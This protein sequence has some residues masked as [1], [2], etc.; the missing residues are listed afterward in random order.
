MLALL[1]LAAW[2]LR[3]H[4][5]LDPPVASAAAVLLHEEAVAAAQRWHQAL[6]KIGLVAS[7]Q[8]HRRGVKCGAAQLLLAAGGRGG[9][10]FA[11]CP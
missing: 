11:R 7:A 9:V 5:P 4:R 1:P 10:Q 2:H 6:L 8:R 3:R